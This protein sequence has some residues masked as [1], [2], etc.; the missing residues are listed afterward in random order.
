[1]QVSI[2]SYLIPGTGHSSFSWSIFWFTKPILGP[3]R[4]NTRTLISTH[5]SCFAGYRAAQGRM[6]S[7]RQCWP[8]HHH[9]YSSRQQIETPRILKLGFTGRL[10]RVYNCH[11]LSMEMWK[12][13]SPHFQYWV[14]PNVWELLRPRV[15]GR[16]KLCPKHNHLKASYWVVFMSEK[17]S[18][19]RIPI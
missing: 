13:F 10:W 3:I 7:P 18:S 19:G 5:R 9:R 8:P 14:W 12:R 16:M 15:E 2:G 17:R 4:G 11:I 1:M 6:G